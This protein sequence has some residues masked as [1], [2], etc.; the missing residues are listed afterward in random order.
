MT[1]PAVRDQREPGYRSGS[2]TTISPLR[3]HRWD[4]SGVLKPSIASSSGSGSWRRYSYA[5]LVGLRVVDSLRNAG[6]SLQFAAA[7]VTC[8][9]DH[10]DADLSSS[11]L[12]LTGETWVLTGQA[13][14]A[15]ELVLAGKGVLVMLS[16][17]SV[18][19]QLAQLDRLDSKPAFQIS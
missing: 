4:K 11:V 14:E 3:L 19:N 18:V 7:A 6:V 16:L 5:D 8:L 10:P 2:V 12:V 17:A 9:Q 15:R 1:G 13:S